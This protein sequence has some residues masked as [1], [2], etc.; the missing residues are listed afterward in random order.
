MEN[1]V[2]QA[3]KQ[4]TQNQNCYEHPKELL[5]PQ[6]FSD[7]IFKLYNNEIPVGFSTGWENVDFKIREQE[8]TII[9]G[10]P[11]SGK[12]AWLDALMANLVSMYQWR[13]AVYSSEVDVAHHMRRFIELTSHKTFWGQFN[14]NKLTEED[15]KECLKVIS[16]YI[17]WLDSTQM[18]TLEKILELI[19]YSAINFGIKA[20]ILDPFGYL[21]AMRPNGMSETEYVSISLQRI[22]NLCKTYNMHCFIVAHPKKMGADGNGKTLLPTAYDISGSAHYFNMADNVVCVHRDKMAKTN[23]NNEVEIWLQKIKQS[24]LGSG[25]LGCYKLHYQLGVGNYVSV[26]DPY[27][28]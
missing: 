1:D 8:L 18:L 21:T 23:P 22:K 17:M 19:E 12:S 25:T 10:I 13:F 9:T 6:S 16:Q 11:A 15:I 4:E 3:I 5:S 2:I 26:S 14:T 20:F 28:N 27:N 24:G 7:N